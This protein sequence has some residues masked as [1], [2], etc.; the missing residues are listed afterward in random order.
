MVYIYRLFFTS[1]YH[2]FVT[3]HE[4]VQPCITQA[5]GMR[6]FFSQWAHFMG[7]SFKKFHTYISGAAFL[8]TQWVYRY[9]A[10]LRGLNS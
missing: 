9:R 4:N 8:C 3:F 1:L 2:I 10:P 7:I 5:H 6:P